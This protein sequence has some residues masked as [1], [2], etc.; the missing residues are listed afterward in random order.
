MHSWNEIPIIIPTLAPDNMDLACSKA[1][2][3]SPR[4]AC[5]VISTVCSRGWKMVMNP[6]GFI[7]ES[8]KNLF[9]KKKKIM[10][11]VFGFCSKERCLDSES[12]F[13]LTFCVKTCFAFF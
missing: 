11:V 8:L 12:V 13:Y 4:A 3:S 7:G 2:I 9:R 5:L 6:Y 10:V 1:S